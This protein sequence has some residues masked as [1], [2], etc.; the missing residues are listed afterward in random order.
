MPLLIR[1]VS[2]GPK[3][4]LGSFC[5]KLKETIA[6][7]AVHLCENDTF[8]PPCTTVKSS[9][10]QCVS[11][12]T[13]LKGKVSSVRPN[14]AAGTCRFY[15]KPGCKDGEGGHFDVSYPG[16]DVSKGEW[17]RPEDFNDKI[18]SF[19]CD[20]AKESNTP[21][22][23]EWS[24]KSQPQLCS[25]FDH[26]NLGFQLSDSSGAG[27]WDTIKL[28]FPNAAS[29]KHVI[30]NGPAAG[31]HEW[32]PI[33]M[34]NVFGSDLVEVRRMSKIRLATEINQA[35]LDFK[36]A[37]EWSL[38]GLKLT[39]RCAK[40]GIWVD[41]DK[42]ASMNRLMQAKPTDSGRYRYHRDW[43]VWA[44]DIKSEDWV[45]RPPCSHFQQMDVRVEMADESWAGTNNDLYIYAGNGRFQIAHQ[46]SRRQ[47][48][49][50]NVNLEVAYRSSA[51][52]V[53]DIKRISI[54]SE[55]G[56][57]NKALASSKSPSPPRLTPRVSGKAWQ[58]IRRAKFRY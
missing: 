55:G 10:G 26:L 5:R 32:Q 57:W 31:F 46:P 12:P 48:Y 23:W 13:S 35:V 16:A 22:Q 28:D 24:P 49:I 20:A 37:D 25:H 43:E 8:N 44:D 54:K 17:P 41:M 29:K 39:A 36:E 27:T 7:P 2:D 9:A 58:L 11:V 4:E 47:S 50:S 45:P 6:K 18:A 19:R 30:A 42:F 1:D 52:P 21:E 56:S 40:S 51:V 33:N 53:A 15:N 34:Q 38:I 3:K 14:E